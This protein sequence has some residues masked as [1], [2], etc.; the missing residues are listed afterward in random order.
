MTIE[1]PLFTRAEAAE[2]LSETY[3]MIVRMN[4]DGRLPYVY[5][6]RHVRIL[7]SDCDDLMKQGRV[8][9]REAS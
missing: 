8:D 2:Y 6:G 9:T 5:I 3:R 7:K 4:R 1:S